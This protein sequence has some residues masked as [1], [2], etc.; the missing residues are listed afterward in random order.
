M[1]GFGTDLDIDSSGRVYQGGRHFSG[2]QI[3]GIFKLSGDFNR[4]I[5]DSDGH[6][7][8]F[9]DIEHQKSELA[10][11]GDSGQVW[12]QKFAQLWF[13]ARASATAAATAFSTTMAAMMF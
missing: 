4:H 7:F 1:R 13:T 8:R 10:F 11:R 12:R 9:V 5:L 2:K 3:I 6:L